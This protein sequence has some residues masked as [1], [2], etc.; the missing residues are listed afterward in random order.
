MKNKIIRNASWIIICRIA[1]SVLTLVIGMLTARYLGPSNYGLIN[2]ASSIV[3]FVTPIMYLGL[4]SILV[5]EIIQNPNQ[6]GEILGTSIVMSLGSAVLCIIGVVSFALV[7]NAGETETLIVC[8]LYSMLLIFQAVDLIQYW[9]QAKLMSKYTSITMLCAYLVV[10]IYK[11]FLLATGK[12]IYWFALS[13]VIDYAIIAIS[14]LIIYK[15]CGGSKFFFS[16]QTGKRLI[17]RSKYYIISSIMTVVFTQTDKVMLKIMLDDAAT[18]YYSAAVTCAGVSSF[19][20]SAIIDSARPT[21]FQS[22]KLCKEQFELNMTRLYSVV[23][24]LSLAQSLFMTILARP[25]INLLYGN[26]YT[27]TANVLRLVVWYTTFSYIGAVRGIWMLAEEKQKY[28]LVANVFGA[29]ANVIVNAILIP[30]YGM[31]GAAFASIA[32]QFFANIGIG[33]IIRPIQR[34]N[35]LVVRA[36]NPVI[37]KEIILRIK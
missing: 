5:Q 10:S 37:L 20:F 3:S 14:L 16:V 31:F 4:N 13:N 24:Y 9:F 15:K 33:Y 11:I 7:A 17:S 26:Q 2:Y 35:I 19:V 23:I 8:A 6:E 18:G 25:I 29:L 27:A 12:N 30:R 22:A 36:L 1:Q 21:I 32:T 28:L 34:N